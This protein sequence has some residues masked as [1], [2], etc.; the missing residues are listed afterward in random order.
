MAAQAGGATENSQECFPKQYIISGNELVKSK[1]FEVMGPHDTW[2]YAQMPTLVSLTI[3]FIDYLLTSC[4]LFLVDSFYG[5]S[6]DLPFLRR[7][8]STSRQD[9]EQ[10]H[11]AAVLSTGLRRT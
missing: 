3:L 6:G 11:C 1:S 10:M 5:T 7:D 2:S 4:D 9:A 8:S